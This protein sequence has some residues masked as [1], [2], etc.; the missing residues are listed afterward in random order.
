[1]ALVP[2][3]SSAWPLVLLPIQIA[4]LEIVIDPSA[5]LAYESEPSS[6]NQ[7][8]AKP[9]SKDEK[10][11]TSKV[12]RLAAVQG[13]IL[14]LGSLSVF[15]FALGAGYEDE[16]VRSV[17]FG[18]ILLG[19]L[20]LMLSN[21]SSTAGLME[22]I[23]GRRNKLA[24]FIFFAGITAMILIFGLAIVR[25]AFG[26]SALQP[27]DIATVLAGALPAVLWFEFYKATKKSSNKEALTNA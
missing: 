7:M 21:R 27:L 3:A 24:L 9:R 15:L 25:Q 16:R 23:S 18:T 12:F 10:L 26:L 13:A 8:Q 22:L 11:I 19:N 4:I 6:K 20:L 17:T 5:S 14:F 1:M 2:I